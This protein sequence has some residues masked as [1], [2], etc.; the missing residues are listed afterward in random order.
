LTAPE[1]TS[2]DPGLT[3]QVRKWVAPVV[4]RW[5]RSEVRALEY[6]PRSG[7][8][9]VVSNHSGGMMTPDVLIFAPASLP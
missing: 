3:K 5:F 2:W 9:L 8:A 7:A 4:Q 6:L 1:V